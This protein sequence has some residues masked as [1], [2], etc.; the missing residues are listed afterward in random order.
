[1]PDSSQPTSAN[2]SPE[3]EQYTLPSPSSPESAMT[4]QP[5]EV[6]VE[7]YREYI[8]SKVA[9]HLFKKLLAVAGLL[10]A[11]VTAYFYFVINY[12]VATKV[13]ETRTQLDATVDEHVNRLTA[14]IP[15]E[16]VLATINNDNFKTELERQAKQAADKQAGPTVQSAV[17]AALE[18]QLKDTR[19][20]L[21][22]HTKDLQEAASKSIDGFAN[23]LVVKS[24]S[25][26]D[27]ATKDAVTKA[28]AA[29][30]DKISASVG[31]EIATQL[32]TLGL[33][34]R[35]QAELENIA[36]DIEEMVVK[37]LKE[38][39]VF[40]DAIRD[41]TVSIRRRLLLD[42]S[43]TEEQKSIA[44]TDI[45][46]YLNDNQVEQRKEVMKAIASKELPATVK[47]QALH[48]FASFPSPKS[49]ELELI[50]AAMEA[51]NLD[52]DAGTRAAL[53]KA[54]ASCGDTAVG[55]LFAA[56]QSP[57]LSIPDIS[58][59][60]RAVAYIGGEESLEGLALLA[61]TQSRPV[62][63]AA[64]NALGQ[65]DP[66]SAS[67]EAR[68][69]VG[70]QLMQQLP[71]H[72]ENPGSVLFFRGVVTRVVGNG[73]AYEIQSTDGNIIV[74]DG[75][76]FRGSKGQQVVVP[77]NRD[78]DDDSRVWRYTLVSSIDPVGDAA[79]SL[80]R[81]LSHGELAKLL[82]DEWPA[83]LSTPAE[84][85]KARDL[86]GVCCASLREKSDENTESLRLALSSKTIQ[87][88]DSLS[89]PLCLEAYAVTLRN[90]EPGTINTWFSQLDRQIL[91]R[92]ELIDTLHEA[93]AAALQRDGELVPAFTNA[94]VLYRSWISG[95][96][97]SWK[98]AEHLAR[99]MLVD[100]K[101]DIVGEDWAMDFMLESIGGP[102]RAEPERWPAALH[103]LRALKTVQSSLYES[104]ASSVLNCLVSLRDANVVKGSHRRGSV[105]AKIDSPEQLHAHVLA[106][107]DLLDT[108]IDNA[109][110]K[111]AILVQ[112]RECLATL[113]AQ[114]V[115]PNAVERV[116]LKEARFHLIELLA[117][118]GDMR[119]IQYVL[120]ELIE[121]PDNESWQGADAA[122]QRI[123]E[124]NKHVLDGT[125]PP[126][127]LGSDMRL[128]ARTSKCA[129]WK[130]WIDSHAALLGM[131]K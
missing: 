68:T 79:R 104:Q 20:K 114:C 119:A 14:R 19:S 48:A 37:T 95:G 64:W 30:G 116:Q 52:G 130:N 100:T 47:A 45:L 77:I 54:I 129:E 4:R 46:F 6:T 89:D 96:A 13:T 42:P 93:L 7:E 56:V 16:I 70:K 125:S 69:R 105:A 131:T 97:R 122:L 2:K 27:Q 84:I 11:G 8:E 43:A 94:K 63:H 66:N 106:I 88:P 49:E 124:R 1:M 112:V 22:Q 123:V 18:V 120:G 39:Q 12:S 118:Q 103:A 59:L 44:L 107:Q 74:Y 92:H 67:G 126:A 10:T 3:L 85:T 75:E 21:E 9:G 26:V 121:G 73:H 55:L 28:T 41:E 65:F 29:V 110:N 38:T 71:G 81:L 35:V 40:R 60:L 53:E 83:T 111:E 82:S 76:E 50:L 58:T 61:N 86:V 127:T 72:V 78:L 62:S 36:P 24:R 113:R 34:K 87:I 101:N 117:E 51:K 80:V 115:D 25:Q 33:E 102:L 23:E 99:A 17:A 128:E 98:F 108:W 31:A 5:A 109:S 91:S 90:A 57:N 32:Q 15:A